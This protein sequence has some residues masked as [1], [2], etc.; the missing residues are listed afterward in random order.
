MSGEQ[1]PSRQGRKGRPATAAAK[2]AKPNSEKPE[3]H[4]EKGGK[5]NHSVV[6]SRMRGLVGWAQAYAL[7]CRDFRIRDSVDHAYAALDEL[8]KAFAD[9]EGSDILI[10]AAGMAFDGEPR[11][12]RI[13]AMQMALTILKLSPADLEVRL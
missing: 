8:G 13:A 6:Q 7:S 3:Q 10:G 5:R 12:D 11:R 2:S 9:S 1:A 4:T